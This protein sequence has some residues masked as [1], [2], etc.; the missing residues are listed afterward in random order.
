MSAFLNMQI[1]KGFGWT[2]PA[3]AISLLLGTGPN[4]FL[5]ALAV[6]LGQTVIS[7]FFDKV[8]G[9]TA[10]GPRSQART[11]PKKAPFTRQPRDYYT[12][13]SSGAKQETTRREGYQSW[14]S[15]D[16]LNDE[17]GASGKKSRAF[18]GWDDLDRKSGLGDN[19]GKKQNRK[20]A[21]FVKKRGKMSRVGRVKETPLLLRLL[22]AAFPFLGSWT[23]LLF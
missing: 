8:M 6:P 2:I 3:I 18:G 4:P 9:M 16:G 11:R 13:A 17:K 23:R 12:R 5:M 20:E 21:G 15:G 1:L 7:L 22:I 14:V 10:E 19:L